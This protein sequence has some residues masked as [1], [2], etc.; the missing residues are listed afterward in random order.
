MGFVIDETIPIALGG[1]VCHANSGP[2]HRWCN[3]IKSTH[4]LEWA[5]AEVARLLTTHGKPPIKATAQPFPTSD[6]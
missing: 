5:Q 3:R 6:W 4:S 2:A 1:K